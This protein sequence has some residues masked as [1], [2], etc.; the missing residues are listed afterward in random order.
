MFF[1]NICIVSPSKLTSKESRQDSLIP[2]SS[3]VVRNAMNRNYSSSD[4]RPRKETS[5]DKP[6]KR[7]SMP[8]SSVKKLISAY[9]NQDKSSKVPNPPRRKIAIPSPPRQKSKKPL[10][11]QTPEK[12]IL[13]D[14]LYNEMFSKIRLEGDKIDYQLKPV[15]TTTKDKVLLD[16]LR[17]DFDSHFCSQ[18]P[19]FGI[20]KPSQDLTT[21]EEIPLRS[22]SPEARNS[23]D[24]SDANVSSTTFDPIL[25][26]TLDS[27]L[28]GLPIGGNSKSLS[29]KLL[30]YYENERQESPTILYKI[31]L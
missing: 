14:T 16:L 19:L 18:R 31:D 2:K 29:N 3:I 21:K 27:L 15:K 25:L 9:E 17:Q 20:R 5:S 1:F 10:K 24:T 11:K 13:R 22:S 26:E 12:Q 7:K 8:R 6:R 30:N 28:F 4:P 23:S